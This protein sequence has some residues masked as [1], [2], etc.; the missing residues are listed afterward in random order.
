MG[1]TMTKIT[2][3]VLSEQFNLLRTDPQKY[4][5]LADEFVRSNPDVPDGYFSR[6]HAWGRL[7]RKD[8]ALADLNKAISLEQHWIN[9]ESRAHL[10]CELGRYREALHDLNRAEAM[11]PE[12]WAGGF[13]LLY[14]ADCHA[15]LGDETAALAD[16]ARLPDD[17]WTPGLYGAPAGNKAQVT[18]EIRRRTAA[19]RSSQRP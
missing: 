17:H 10:L 12:E 18:E 15:R 6:H 2:S 3:D 11:D 19:A 14:R 9:Y 16:C 4:L 13:G 7:G 5:S 8:L 1:E